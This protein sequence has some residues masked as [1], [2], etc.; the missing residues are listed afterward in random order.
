MT[1][2]H[3][4]PARRVDKGNTASPPPPTEAVDR[5]LGMGS[6]VEIEAALIT[7]G[8]TEADAR[9]LIADHNTAVRAA[10]LDRLAEGITDACPDHSTSDEVWM[11]CH[12]DV[13]TE[14]RNHASIVRAGISPGPE[15][16]QRGEAQ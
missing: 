16:G 12:C 14:L 15:E 9:Q 8:F 4:L 7:S 3:A 10:E 13:A 6:T 11:V 2:E 5:E 1:A